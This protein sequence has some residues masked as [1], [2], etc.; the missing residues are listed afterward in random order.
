MAVR[1]EEEAIENNDLPDVKLIMY[2]SSSTG[3]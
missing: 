3:I 1:L 2:T